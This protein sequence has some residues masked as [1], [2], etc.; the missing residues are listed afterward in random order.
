MTVGSGFLRHP[1]G[2]FTISLRDLVDSSCNLDCG[3]ETDPSSSVAGRRIGGTVARETIEI[4]ITVNPS[5]PDQS[6]TS[7]SRSA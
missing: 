2:V 7:A 4:L 3:E 6:F 5:L 1:G